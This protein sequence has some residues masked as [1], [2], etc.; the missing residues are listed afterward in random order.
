VAFSGRRWRKLGWWKLFGRVDDVG[1]LSSEM[2][3][4]CF[5]PEAQKRIIYLA[6]RINEAIT[7]ETKPKVPQRPQRLALN[8]KRPPESELRGRWPTQIASTRNYLLEESVPA[9][10]ALAQRLV[11]QTL[12]T[13]ALASSLAGLVYLS[14]FGAY[15]AAAIAAL[16]IVWSMRRMQNKWETA[17]SF[18]EGEVRE[19]G[20]KAV[21]SVEVEMSTVLESADRPTELD[22]QMREELDTARALLQD[23]RE[24]FSRLK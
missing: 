17:R 16:G 18:W 23:A 21:R 3:T 10:Q 20:R 15:E 7:I 22:S 2:L 9:F 24:T 14:S 5:L 19:E 13:T 1:T 8:A 6:G 4:Q 12:G 11:A